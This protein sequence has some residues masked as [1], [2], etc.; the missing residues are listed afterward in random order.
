MSIIEIRAERARNG[1]KR[2][3]DLQALAEVNA[4]E[5][6]SRFAG[7]QVTERSMTAFLKMKSTLKERVP[8]A[9]FDLWIEPLRCEGEI[10]GQLL[11]SGPARVTTWIERRY[12]GAIADV[13]GQVSD[14]TGVGV[15]PAGA[16]RRDRA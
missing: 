5:A 1:S 2:K 7:V 12:L 8:T 9:T 14:F 10:D 4:R 11:L 13:V 3:R 6:A 16:F 15:A